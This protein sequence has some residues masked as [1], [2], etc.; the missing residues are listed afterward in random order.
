[1]NIQIFSIAFAQNSDKSFNGNEAPFI[2]PPESERIAKAPPIDAVSLNDRYAVDLEDPDKKEGEEK[3]K[4]R[5]PPLTE[6]EFKKLPFDSNT[7][8]NLT[9]LKIISSKTFDPL[10][11]IVEEIIKNDTI[12]S[13]DDGMYSFNS[14]KIK[15]KFGETHLE[16]IFIAQNMCRDSETYLGLNETE[17]IYNTTADQDNDDNILS[18]ADLP[19]KHI[20]TFITNTKVDSNVTEGGEGQSQAVTDELATEGKVAEAEIQNNEKK[21]Q[22][23]GKTITV[24]EIPIQSE[25]SQI[26]EATEGNVT[27]KGLLIINNTSEDSHLT[28]SSDVGDENEQEEQTP[29]LEQT[30]KNEDKMKVTE[31]CNDEKDNDLDGIIDEKKDCFNK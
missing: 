8:P 15:N 22:N 17:I 16:K 29:S 27:I 19:N 9:E 4:D 11:S 20:L 5:L 26:E 1:M 30:T 7:D 21:L 31:V 24:E 12:L 28:T 2:P 23:E 3:E 6:Q 14:S 13:D 25:E 10:T 18:E